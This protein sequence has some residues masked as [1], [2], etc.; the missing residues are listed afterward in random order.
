[1][2][3]ITPEGSIVP[4]YRAEIDKAQQA[5][6]QAERERVAAEHAATVEARKAPLRRLG[7]TDTEID[8]VLG[9]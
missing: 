2:K 1:M 9:I 6:D 8:T 7:L 5:A 4:V 3:D